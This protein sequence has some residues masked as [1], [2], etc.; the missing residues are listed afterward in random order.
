MGLY[1]NIF[2]L[3]LFVSVHYEMIIDFN[4]PSVNKADN[5]LSEA[6]SYYCSKQ[7]NENDWNFVTNNNID[8]RYGTVIRNLFLH[9]V[10][11][12]FLSNFQKITKQWHI[13]IYFVS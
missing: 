3:I 7:K 10:D 12:L 5:V 2:S 6:A 8:G 11:F 13:Q 1:T 9:I 4:G